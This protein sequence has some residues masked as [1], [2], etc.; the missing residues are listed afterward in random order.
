MNLIPVDFIL[1]LY[2]IVLIGVWT[3]LAAT[4]D[5]ARWMIAVHAGALAL[6]LLFLRAGPIRSPI[7]AAARDLYPMIWL[8]TFWRELGLHTE[9]VGS[10]PNDT[11]L[12]WLDRMAFGANWNAV[13]PVRMPMAWFSELMQGVYFLYYVLFVGLVV[14]LLLTRRRSTVRDV[15]LRLSAAYAAAYF[16]YAIAPTLGPM[17]MAGFPRFGGPGAHGVFRMLNDALQAAGDAAGTAFPSTHVAGGV[18]LA[19]LAWLY[20]PKPFAWFMT[21]LAVTIAPATVY[22]Q[23]H[24]ALD[25]LCGGLLGIWLQGWVVPALEGVHRWPVLQALRVP[26]AVP[27]TEPE[28][29]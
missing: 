14:Y 21:G 15:I 1:A 19:W 17:G 16:V 18:T 8:S 26:R 25:A 4:S 29:A 13:W 10:A 9:L 24:F 6:P 3:P 11:L 5:T 7:V 2:N 22:T 20:C 12:A 27:K 23:N 28:A